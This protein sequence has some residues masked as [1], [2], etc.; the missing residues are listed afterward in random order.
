M[1]SIPGSGRSPG[2]GTGN[3]LQ[4]SCLGNPMD[5]GAWRGYSPWGCQQSDMTEQ[6]N[7]PVMVKG[8]THKFISCISIINSVF[9]T[10]GGAKT[11]RHESH[12]YKA[13]SYLLCD[14]HTRISWPLHEQHEH[15]GFQGSLESDPDGDL[16]L[17]HLL[18]QKAKQAEYYD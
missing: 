3:P 13:L 14:F 9:H 11:L 18:A 7:T 12:V 5:R 10:E 16:L 1:S 15:G 6:L 17:G 8:R 2:V 4:Y